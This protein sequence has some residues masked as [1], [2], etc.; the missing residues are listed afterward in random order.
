MIITTNIKQEIIIECRYFLMME[1][2]HESNCQQQSWRRKVTI[3][4]KLD[5]V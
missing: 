2:E 3:S 4:N 1:M 5:K